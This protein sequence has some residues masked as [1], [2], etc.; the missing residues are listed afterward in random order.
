MALRWAYFDTSVLLKQYI[1]E[2]G[3][4]RARDLLRRFRFLSCAL[5]PLEA[6]SALHPRLAEGA[7]TQAELLRITSWIR[8]DRV[9]WE[10]VEVNAQVLS[11]AEDVIQQTGLRTLDAIHVASALAFQAASRIRLPFVTGD[12][13]QREAARQLALETVWVGSAPVQPNH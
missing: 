2:V 8:E 9:H 7:L 11:R 13:R 4:L 6:M 5:T 3:S 10:L 12:A 1:R